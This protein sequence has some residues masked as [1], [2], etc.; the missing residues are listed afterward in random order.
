MLFHASGSWDA[1][2]ERLWLANSLVIAR[3]TNEQIAALLWHFEPFQTVKIKGED[4]IWADIGRVIARARK[5]HPTITPRLYG[6]RP[7]KPPKVKRGRAGNHA[8][9]VEQVYQVLLDHR[10]GE[11]AI[12]TAGQVAGVINCARE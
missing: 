12:V 2:R 4:A 1:S 7:A 6:A 11:Q 5:A 3:Y 9:L 10:A 8:D